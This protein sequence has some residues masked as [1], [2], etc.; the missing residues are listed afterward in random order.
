[1]EKN[2]TD[3]YPI[4]DNLPEKSEI[5]EK[6]LFKISITEAQIEY[7]HDM[8]SIAKVIYKIENNFNTITVWRRFSDF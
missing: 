4:L 6:A 1:M 5:C 3:V 8:F 2:L 7:S